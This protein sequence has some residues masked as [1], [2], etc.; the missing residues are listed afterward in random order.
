MVFS[1]NQWCFPRI[2]GV[3]P[4]S[5]VF[6]FSFHFSLYGRRKKQN[7]MLQETGL[8]L[9]NDENCI[10]FGDVFVI[11]KFSLLNTFV[12]R[13]MSLGFFPEIK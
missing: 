13:K 1:P 5:M 9:K 7:N 3:F 11:M 4:E 6:S 8:S 2:N 10:E 12:K